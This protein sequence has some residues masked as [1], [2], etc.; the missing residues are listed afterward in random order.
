MNLLLSLNFR[1]EYM[2]YFQDTIAN[3]LGNNKLRSPQIEAYM[4]IQA[5]FAENPRGEALAV[6]PT[7]TGKSGL[8]SIAPF[9][10]SNGRVLII[11]PGLVTKE[12]IRKTQEVLEDNFWVNFDIIFDPSH[13]PVVTEYSSEVS[14]EHLK[15]SNFIYS[16]IQRI[17]SNN[18][19]G[20]INR[21]DPQFFDMIIIDEGHHS[22]A[23]SWKEVISYF[24]DSKKLHLTG[25][26]YRGD[27]QELPG[28][29]IHETPLSEVMRDKY[30]KWLR[31]ETVNA[32]KLYFTI[33]E[34]PG[35]KL[36]KDEV[37]EL[38]DR[39]WLEKSV[40]LSDECSSDVIQ[41][42]ISKLNEFKELSPS[43]P[44]KILAVGCS[45]L[46]AEKINLLYQ[47]HGLRTVIVHSNMSSEDL[48]SNF[49]LI[50][51]HECDVVISVNMLMEGYDN[52]YLSILALF[53]PYRSLNA[54]AQIV[55]RILRAIPANE[56]TAFEIDNNAVVIYHEETG[57]DI[58][59]NSFQQE[60]DRAKYQRIKEYDIA[61]REYIERDTNLAEINTE[62]SFTSNRS[63]Y[64]E[65]I[66]F[67]SLFE[68]KRAEI[69][70]VVQA[71]LQ[72]MAQMPELDQEDIDF[73]RKKLIQKEMKKVAFE[74]IDPQLINL[75]PDL[76][77][78]QLREILTKKIQDEAT[79]LLSDFKITEKGTDLFDKFRNI[80][81]GMPE[82]TPNDA[83]I[84]RYINS[85][86]SKKFKAVK[87]RDNSTLLSS[88]HEI[89]S[90]IE[91]L[92][93]MLTC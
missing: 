56:I 85:K 48:N 88:L 53:R 44:H 4:E 58:M 90:V 2:S 19:G 37:L 34:K 28:K 83:V 47:Q 29:K 24:S 17:T 1:K 22:P 54:F 23:Q 69:S 49:Q 86:L 33:L 64:L 68:E 8:I 62:N 72:A 12:S 73:L 71:K 78:K 81:Y 70:L 3:I 7:G 15:S 10:V 87:T 32:F 26:P 65:D 77:R 31:K 20:L 9:G 82:E 25:T 91:E 75:R 18:K 66:D 50:D 5:Y 30:V 80:I 45:I 6:L 40:A 16:N 74:Y 21:V 55:G 52:K 93:R 27:N 57:L 39:E 63:S 36:S 41:H 42:S 60:V 38:K 13:I 51:D 61:D 79:N 67:N 11:T 35:V 14:V 92:R 84:V 76:A 89:N 46:H 43:V 59:W